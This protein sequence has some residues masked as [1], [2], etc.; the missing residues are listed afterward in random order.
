[1]ALLLSGNFRIGR[2]HPGGAIHALNRGVAKRVKWLSWRPDR[3]RPTLT[4]SDGG[5]RLDLATVRLQDNAYRGRGRAIVHRNQREF[6]EPVGPAAIIP[7]RACP[8]A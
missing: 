8:V 2:L 5:N 6:N 3:S 4:G 1:M 7:G